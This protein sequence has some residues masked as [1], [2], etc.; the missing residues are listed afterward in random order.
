MQMLKVFGL[1]TGLTLILVGIGGY[2]GGQGGAYLMFAIAAAMNFGTY[3]FSDRMVLRMYKAQII[4]RSQAPDLYAMVERLAQRGGVPMPVVA[5]APS[6]QP[7]AF[8]TGRS[9]EK[10]V[11]C[12][13]QG[14]LRALPLEEKSRQAQGPTNNHHRPSRRRFAAAVT[15]LLALSTWEGKCC[16]RRPSWNNNTAVT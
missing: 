10:G 14:I 15:I 6:E 5:I 12:F 3:W 8:A 16:P 11:V 13:T 9:P 2:F 1:M 4:D 7:N